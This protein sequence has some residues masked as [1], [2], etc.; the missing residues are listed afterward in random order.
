[1]NKLPPGSWE[2][3][4]VSRHDIEWLYKSRRVSSEVICRRPGNELTPTPQPGERV[5]FITHFERGFALPASDLLALSSTSMVSNHIT[6]PPIPSFLYPPSR[7]SAKPILAFGPPPSCGPSSSASASI[8]CRV[9]TTS[10][11]WPAARSAS[12]RESSQSFLESRGWT[13]LRNGRGR[14]ST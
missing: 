3:S 8:P 4:E 14:S 2:G 12:R 10:L 11:W 9:L 13:R 6:S 5:V 1:M 7:L